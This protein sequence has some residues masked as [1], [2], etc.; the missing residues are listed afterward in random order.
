MIDIML[1]DDGDIVLTD[2]GDIY[3]TQS[4]KQNILIRLKWFF[5]EWRLGPDLGFPWFEEVLVKNPNLM[6]IKG[7]VRNEI[8]QIDGVQS[9]T[10]DT[11]NYNAQ[12]RTIEIKYTVN[13]QGSILRES[14]LIYV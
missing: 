7:L 11:V 9:C 8:M 1:G 14:A 12:E 13:A 2:Y 10:V 4:I 3:L 5:K 6:K